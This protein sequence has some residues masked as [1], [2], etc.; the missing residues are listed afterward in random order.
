MKNKRPDLKTVN[1]IKTPNITHIKKIGIVSRDYRKKDE[2]GFRDFSYTFKNILLHLNNQDCDS[3]IFPMYTLVKREDFD[4]IQI[5]NQL[6]IDNLKTIFIAEFT[7]GIER[8]SGDYII[9]YKN[10]DEWQEYRLVQKFSSLKYTQSFKNKIIEPFKSEVN[11]QRL[12]G[13]CTVLLSGES[14]IVKFSQTRERVEDQF[15]YLDLLNQDTPIILNPVH[16]RMMRHEIKLKRQFLSEQGRWVISVWN[17]GKADKNGKVKN[18]K[19]PAWM[20]FYNGKEKQ[21]KP[22]INNIP[23]QLNIEIGV[24]DLTQH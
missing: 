14:N 1:S 19:N 17:K 21:I 5:L 18:S 3:V 2:N 9:Y 6:R 15:Q 13:N 23:T 22:I 10:K 16:E 20:V 11:N 12:L 24:I 4:A 8:E 7:D